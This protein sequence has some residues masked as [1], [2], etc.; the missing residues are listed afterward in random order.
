[1]SETQTVVEETNGQVMPAPAEVS[2]V[3]TEESQDNIDLEA[4]LSEWDNGEK[5][6]AVEPVKEEVK[7][8][9]AKAVREQK[10]DEVRTSKENTVKEQTKS[11]KD[12]QTSPQNSFMPPS[13]GNMPPSPGNTPKGR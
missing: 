2:G 9:K 8:E 5:Q 7:T 12:E 6:K 11:T 3:Q 10:E 1:M 13:P 4:L